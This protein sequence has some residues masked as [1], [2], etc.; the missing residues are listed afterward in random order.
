MFFIYCLDVDECKV[1]NPCM[2]GAKCI[3]SIG[4]YSCQCPANF[5]GKHCDEGNRTGSS[6]GRVSFREI[7]CVIF[8]NYP[9]K[10]RGISS[11]T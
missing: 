11:D 10:S 7:I 6:H 4:G 3:N 9:A 1:R 8:N 2:N 5:K